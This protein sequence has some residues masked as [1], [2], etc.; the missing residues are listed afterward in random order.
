M[1]SIPSAVLRL[2]VLAAACVLGGCTYCVDV[3]NTT[4]QPVLVKM[5]QVDPIQPDWV[6][7]SQRISPGDYAKL[8]PSRVP[9][10][11]VVIEVDN[12]T[13][14][15]TLAR[16]SISPGSTRL[17][18]GQKPSTEPGRDEVIFTLQRRSE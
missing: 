10:E 13:E 12:Q 7:A 9:F 5:V 1:S 16:Y 15:S 17:D 6:L 4:Q 14:R 11:R 8:G 3:R 18:V 2:G